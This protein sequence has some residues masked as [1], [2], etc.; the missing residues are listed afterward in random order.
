MRFIIGIIAIV[1]LFKLA[2]GLIGLAFIWGNGTSV[3]RS[4]C[5]AYFLAESS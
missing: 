2:V 3:S 4:P 5:G 1:V